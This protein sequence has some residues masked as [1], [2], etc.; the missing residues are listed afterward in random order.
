MVVRLFE[1]RDSISNDETFLGIIRQD[2]TLIIFVSEW[3]DIYKTGDDCIP[4]LSYL[5]F[6]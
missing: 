5:T 1:Q 6:V 4:R 3:G 2:K